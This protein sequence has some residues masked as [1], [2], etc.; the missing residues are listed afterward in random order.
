MGWNPKRPLVIMIHMRNLKG[1]GLG[2]PLFWDNEKNIPGMW[3]DRTKMQ[4]LSAV[5][6]D[7]V[8]QQWQENVQQR[9]VACCRPNSPVLLQ[10]VCDV[11][12]WPTHHTPGWSE[13][14]SR[15][16][17]RDLDQ[18]CCRKTVLLPSYF[19]IHHVEYATQ[20]CDQKKQITYFTVLWSYR[21]TQEVTE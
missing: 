13:S 19:S 16:S 21:C 7:S 15:L 6:W 10:V 18:V 8:R 5:R 4:W 1:M 14:F 9:R 20:S 3:G 17:R 2:N 11:Q 12:K